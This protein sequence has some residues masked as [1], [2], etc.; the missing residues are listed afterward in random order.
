M[1][2]QFAQ[3]TEVYRSKSPILCIILILIIRIIMSFKLVIQNYKA[4]VVK[5][6]EEN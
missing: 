4:G 6:K 2:A 3:K 5:R 1:D